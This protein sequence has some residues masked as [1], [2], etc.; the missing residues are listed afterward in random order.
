MTTQ[1]WDA[2]KYAADFE[3]E[4]LEAPASALTNPC[5]YSPNRAY[6]G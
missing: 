1:D 2:V 5:E 4:M 3:N 6:G